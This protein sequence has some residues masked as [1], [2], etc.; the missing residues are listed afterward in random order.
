MAES[1]GFEPWEQLPVQRIS[2][3]SHST[4]LATLQVGAHVS[5]FHHFGESC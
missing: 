1:Q 5:S 2:N 3:P 4:T